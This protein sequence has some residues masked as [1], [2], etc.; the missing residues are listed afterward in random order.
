MERDSNPHNHLAHNWTLNH[1]VKLTTWLSCVMIDYLYGSFD[2]MFL[3]YV[4]Y[5]FQSE[6]TLYSCLNVEELFAQNRPGIWSLSEW[7]GASSGCEFGSHRSQLNFRYC[8]CSEQGFPWHQTSIECDFALKN[9]RDMIR[10]YSHMHDRD[11]YSQH[12][13]II[14]LV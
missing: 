10:N 1:L 11:K 8:T 6:S 9:V 14:W 13:L 2:S 7:N 3:Y 12:S 4:T 5:V